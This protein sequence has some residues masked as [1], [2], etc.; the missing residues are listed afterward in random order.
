MSLCI[1]DSTIAAYMY[2]MAPHTYQ[3][4]RYT[5]WFGNYISGQK[6]EMEKMSGY[7]YYQ[8]RIKTTSRAVL[9]LD[10]FE[11][12]LEQYQLEDA[13]LLFSRVQEIEFDEI[14]KV[15]LYENEEVVKHFPPQYIV[16]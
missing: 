13:S 15:W 5:D 4:A 12:V 9:M 10:K 11:K 7:A 14:R 16:G 3:Y 8:D 2:R 1:K 6:D